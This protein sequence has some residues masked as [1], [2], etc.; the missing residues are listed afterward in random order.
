MLFEAAVV[1]CYLA[2]RL[3]F[4]LATLIDPSLKGRLAEADLSF[5]V[6]S[7]NGLS[8]GLFELRGGRLGY[9]RRC[10]K[11]ADF[12]VTWMGWGDADTWGKRL[13]LHTAEFLNRGMI[14]LEGDLS[15]VIAFFMFLGEA[16]GSLRRIKPAP[17]RRAELSEEEP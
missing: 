4:S 12:T 17:V 16:L 8:A 2:L 3:L 15:C 11:P 14:T 10:E 1:C 5:A 9:R 6:R 13:R 7:G